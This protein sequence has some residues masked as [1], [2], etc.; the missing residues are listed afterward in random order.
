MHAICTDPD[1]CNPPSFICFTFI[2][3][4]GTGK[5]PSELK[6]TSMTGNLTELLQVHW[7]WAVL[8]V[9]VGVWAAWI[10]H[11]LKPALQ[12]ALSKEYRDFSWISEKKSVKAFLKS[13]L[14]VAFKSRELF[15]EIHRKVCKNLWPVF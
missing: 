12:A 11:L 13:T 10:H 2:V 15:G 6:I 14:D 7:P 5:S 8:C 4:S 3:N 1:V 9:S